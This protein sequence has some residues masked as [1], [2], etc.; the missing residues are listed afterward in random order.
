VRQAFSYIAVAFNVLVV[1]L[2]LTKLDLM[3]V[4]PDRALARFRIWG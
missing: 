2:G 4:S 3:I 1:R